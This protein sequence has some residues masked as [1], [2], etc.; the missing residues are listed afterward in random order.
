MCPLLHHVTQL[1]VSLETLVEI[2]A[3]AF[4]LIALGV[5]SVAFILMLER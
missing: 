3:I 5:G 1:L 4:P 2:M